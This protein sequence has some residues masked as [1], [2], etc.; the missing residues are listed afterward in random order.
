MRYSF[1]PIAA[2]LLSI[3]ALPSY[4]QVIRAYGQ[5]YS[6][7]IKG[8]TTMIGNT[9]LHI[10]DNNTANSTKMN[11]TSNASNGQ[12]GLGFS[13]Y[14]N[15]NE[16]MQN[17]DI[18]GTTA[19]SNLINL[20]AGAWYYLAN[21]S[22][23][24]TAWRSLNAP[25]SPW[26]NGTAS[27]GYGRG[28]NTTITPTNN[29]ITSYYVKNFTI[30]D[31]AAFTQ[32]N[33]VMSYDDGAVVYV[34]GTEVK[35]SNMPS[36]TIAYNTTAS[37]NNYTSGETFTVPVSAFVAGN[38][39]IAVE[40][41]QQ[42]AGSGDCYFD[43]SITGV[44]KNTVNSSSADLIL[45]AG[46]NTVKFARL[47][48]GGRISN[49]IITASPD[50][51][52]KIKIKKNNGVYV[53]Y[54]TSAANV[55]QYAIT[56][57]EKVYQSY[58]D[59]KNLLNT[60]GTTTYT[61]A[62]IPVNTGSSG[63]GG[64]YGGWSILVVYEN[65]ALPYNSVRVY[66]GYLQVYNGGS[67][68]TQSI[69][70]SGL[71]VPNNTL[72]AND[73][74]FTTM[75]WEGDANLSA[76]SSN[77]SGDFIR[78]NGNTFSNAVNPATNMWNGSISKN[79]TLV[80]SRN[81][82][83][84]NQMGIDIDEAQIGVGFGILPNANDVTITFGTEADQYFPSVVGFAIAMKDPSILIDKNVTDANGTGYVE[85]NEVLTYTLTGINNGPGNAYNC[86][87]V[88]TLPL[89][90]SYEPNTMEVISCPGITPGIKPDAVTNDIAMIGTAGAKTYLKFNIGTGATDLLGGVLAQG[91]TYSLR[92]KTKVGA[93]P[94][95]ITN[96]ARIMATSQALENFVDDGTALIST[97]TGGPLA[98]KMT[99]FTAIRNGDNILLK[100]IT[101][102]EIRNDRFEIERS[103]DAV[104][105]K[106][107]GT[108]TGNGSSSLQHDYFFSDPLNTSVKVLYYRLRVVDIDG[109]YNYSNIIAVRL[110]GTLITNA[111]TAY[112][113]PFIDNIKISINSDTEQDAVVR[114]LTTDGKLALARIVT[115]A[116]G[117]NIIVLTDAG[118]L[119]KGAYILELTRNNEKIYQTMVKL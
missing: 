47:Y 112:P 81:P 39:T 25:S 104:H 9:I 89:A 108:V 12:G 11:E 105:F 65:S 72:S 90:L 110:N 98:V 4:S 71:N 64:A 46:T 24:G 96:T 26:I 114:M 30:P 66:D 59:I 56:T 38:N 7:N 92:F 102:A 101:N 118:K 10:V 107:I 16:N 79:G 51:L 18:D 28:Q 19:N 113:N 109:K 48:W 31:P 119:T 63:G 40:V 78:I 95:S 44:S 67:S 82:A 97:I 62:D 53:S 32:F 111:V 106:K 6:D 1:T 27:F 117:A 57:S 13:Q 42:A 68:T 2:L 103:D 77:P 15:D 61:V 43:L 83:Y 52:T 93:V 75:A 23:Q 50:T 34:N 17:I 70:L 84:S 86:T 3:A 99:A 55:D 88:D 36:T 60:S 94:G 37:S 29:S 74:V 69:T 80:T 116:K 100:W 91:E 45:P 115:L 35:R 54:T 20:G 14:G 49:S 33:F 58:V 87:I 8:T 5:V 22:N 73:A 41:H 21:N 76:S 85:P